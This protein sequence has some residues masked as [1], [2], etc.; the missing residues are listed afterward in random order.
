MWSCRRSAY[1]CRP[2]HR[3]FPGEFFRPGRC[4]NRGEAPCRVGHYY[5]NVKVGSEKHV[6]DDVLKNKYLITSSHTAFAVAYLWDITLQILFPHATFEGLANISTPFTSATYLL[7]LCE[8]ARTSIQNA[9]P[10]LSSCMHS[11]RLGRGS[12]LL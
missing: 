4:N 8:S 2:I 11:L 7:T 12:M 3:R 1:L 6:D 10:R 5:G 9:L